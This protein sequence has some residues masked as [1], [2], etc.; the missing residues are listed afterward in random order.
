MIYYTVTV[1]YAIK[2]N[3]NNDYIFYIVGVVLLISTGSL[4]KHA[5]IMKLENIRHK[6][7]N[8]NK[9]KN[10]YDQYKEETQKRKI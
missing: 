7:R 4:K 3:Y 6:N 10:K 8:R 5:G 2:T 1:L 9:Y